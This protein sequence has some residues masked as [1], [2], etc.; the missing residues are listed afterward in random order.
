MLKKMLSRSILI[1]RTNSG[2]DH[3]K[4]P[5]NDAVAKRRKIAAMCAVSWEGFGIAETIEAQL[6]AG[7]HGFRFPE[8]GE[9]R[10]HIILP[11]EGDLR[12]RGTSISS[13]ART[14]MN[15]S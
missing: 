6:V 10:M 5:A 12:E 13:I 3:K 15:I 9:D 14:R 1:N 11:N 2:P 4:K 8:Y 7:D